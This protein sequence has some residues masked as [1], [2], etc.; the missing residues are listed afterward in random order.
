MFYLQGKPN[1]N[2]YPSAQSQPDMGML[3]P[4]GGANT[5]LAARDYKPRS[6]SWGRTAEIQTLW[7]ELA[8]T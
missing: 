3:P 8:A 1:T 2:P 6:H 7:P 5:L 4:H